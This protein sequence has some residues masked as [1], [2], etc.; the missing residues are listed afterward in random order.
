MNLFGQF[1]DLLQAEAPQIPADLQE[2]AL[3]AIF[4]ARDTLITCEQTINVMTQQTV[5]L[6][7]GMDFSFLY[8]E[9]RSLFTIGF[10]AEHA[11]K[12]QSFYD[13]LASEARLLS[14]LA[15]ARGEGPQ[16]HWFSLGRSLANTPGGKALVSWSGTMFE[17]LMPLLLMPTYEHTLLDETYRTVVRRQIEYGRHR[18]VP[19]GI[20]ESCY[21]L[22]DAQG[23][24]CATIGTSVQWTRLRIEQQLLEEHGAPLEPL[25]LLFALHC[26]QVQQNRAAAGAAN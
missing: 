16:K 6:I 12:D 21:H 25:V 26:I 23:T 10:N 19:W 22:T 13:L 8:D 18:G 4:A 7:D 17:Y 20:S 2:E 11:R 24:V 3:R 5:A 14:F 1:E 9:Y 15:V